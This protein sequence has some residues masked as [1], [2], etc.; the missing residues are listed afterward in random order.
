[1]LFGTHRESIALV[2]AIIKNSSQI[3]SWISIDFHSLFIV[4][5]HC[6][7]KSILF[8]FSRMDFHQASIVFFLCVVTYV[9][10][11]KSALP[12][13]K[14]LRFNGFQQPLRAATMTT[15]IESSNNNNIPIF[16]ASITSKSNHCADHDSASM[17]RLPISLSNIKRQVIKSH[18][19]I[20]SMEELS[21]EKS[22]GG[23]PNSNLRDE[24][25]MY[26]LDIL[27]EEGDNQ[28]V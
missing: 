2:R 6:H 28:I 22:N 12:H 10:S 15:V 5:I 27:E 25:Y 4:K 13:A 8:I 11:L 14:L 24:I 23:Y 20:S 9:S 18:N 19:Q 7:R 21:R 1:M 3:S 26:L 17:N 16:T